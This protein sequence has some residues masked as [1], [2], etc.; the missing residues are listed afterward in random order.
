MQRLCG[1]VPMV[2]LIT[3]SVEL[4]K[5]AVTGEYHILTFAETG[6]AALNF[7]GGKFGLNSDELN[8]FSQEINRRD[9]TG[10]LHPRAPISAVPRSY[11]RDAFDAGQLSEKIID[12]L[13]SN[14]SEIHAGQILIDFRAGVAPF[15][16]EAIKQAFN[17]PFADQ[18]KE[19]VVIDRN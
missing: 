17:S 13:R 11:I 7:Y 9:E 4:P 5:A 14:Y 2:E 18:L 16:L 8:L 6:F 10:S 15:V 3:W 1:A 19:V 12:F